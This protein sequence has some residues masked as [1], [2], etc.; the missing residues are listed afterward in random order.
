VYKAC[1]EQYPSLFLGENINAYRKHFRDR[2]ARYSDTR[3]GRM[4]DGSHR[5]TPLQREIVK[6]WS[7]LKPYIKHRG[8]AEMEE[9]STLV[10]AMYVCMYVCR[11]IYGIKVKFSNLLLRSIVTQI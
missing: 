3:K 7:Y 9:V 11:V 1:L 5:L 6:R 8:A 10:Y 2:Y 4:G